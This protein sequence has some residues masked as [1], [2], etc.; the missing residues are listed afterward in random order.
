[1]ATPQEIIDLA[2]IVIAAQ[3]A[4]A[5]ALAAYQVKEAEAAALVAT[6][7]ATLDAAIDAY[8]AAFPIA[9]ATVGWGA[10]ND[11]YQV[12]S[13][14]LAAADRALAEFVTGYSST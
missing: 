12:A 4:A 14:A 9:Q 11:A 3:A 10:A 8:N 7:R 6:E 2:T 13:Q 5:A 1:M